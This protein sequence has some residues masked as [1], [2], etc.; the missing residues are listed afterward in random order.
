MDEEEIKHRAIFGDDVGYGKPPEQSRF[1]KG[2]SGNPKGRPKKASSDLSLT[3][4]PMLSA[5][6]GVANK[7][8][9]VRDGGEM[10]EM[11]MLE[12]VVTATAA[13]AVKG[14]ARSQATFIGLAQKAH[15]AEVLE[16]RRS[17]KLW[18]EYKRVWSAQIDDAKKRGEPAPSILPHP[19]DIVIDYTKGP[20][21]LGPMDEKEQAAVNQALRY[22]DVLM[23][24]D[25]LDHRSEVRLN[26][27]RL[28]EPGSASLMAMLLEMAIPPRLRL[29]EIQWLMRAAKYESMPKRM[30]LKNL[31]EAWSKL[32]SPRPRGYVSANLSWTR[33]YLATAADMLRQI[34]TGKL[35]PD[36]MSRDEW[37]EAIYA[38]NKKHSAESPKAM[39]SRQR[40]NL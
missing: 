2:Q 11:S 35:D 24:Q 4:Q 37:D 20:Q 25:A 15:E 33:N 6:L 28:T 8:V 39:P 12:A 36:R 22:R 32:G 7:T 13:C 38:L 18:A 3:D 14:N 5:V 1:K 9:P 31:F 34:Q 23:M 17:I 27:E 21:F 40:D 16:R 29:S 19:D 10:T 30:L 26:G